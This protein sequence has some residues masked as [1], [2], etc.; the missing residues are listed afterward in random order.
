MEEPR[1]SLTARS[2]GLCSLWP[3]LQR[4]TAAHVSQ[5]NDTSGAGCRTLA[6]LIRSEHAV[7]FHPTTPWRELK[8]VTGRSYAVYVEV[9]T[10]AML[11]QMHVCC[12]KEPAM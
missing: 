4:I 7:A 11:S 12:L 9:L 6:V 1:L 8:E 10:E 5:S 2:V 3:P